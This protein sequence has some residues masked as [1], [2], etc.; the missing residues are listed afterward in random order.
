VLTLT[1]TLFSLAVSIMLSFQG[2]LNAPQSNLFET[3]S[4]TWK[5]GFGA[6][7]GLFG[8]RFA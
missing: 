8:G 5:L 4:T 6:M 7:V 3:C 2:Q 1:L